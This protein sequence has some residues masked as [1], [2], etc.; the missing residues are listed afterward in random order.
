MPY[1]IGITT[2]PEARCE[3][4]QKQTTGFTNWQI[5]EIFRS[6]AAAKEYETEY[7][8][9][10]GCE[11]AA[12]DSDAPSARREPTTEHDW[13]YVYYFDYETEKSNHTLSR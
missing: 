3:Y 13:W 1:K 5:L 10:H 4:W 6:H 2:N 9:R 8:L 7:A 12:G 11:V